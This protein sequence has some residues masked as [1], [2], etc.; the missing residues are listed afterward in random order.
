MV[1]C[2]ITLS[3]DTTADYCTAVISTDYIIGWY[4][5]WA[6]HSCRVWVVLC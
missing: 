4:H 3:V 2:D 1:S 5:S 6:L